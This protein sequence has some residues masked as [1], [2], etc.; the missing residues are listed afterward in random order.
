MKTFLTLLGVYTIGEGLVL[1]L[2]PRSYLSFRAG[3][4]KRLTNK[5][6]RPML[7]ER[8]N[9]ARLIGVLESILGLCLVRRWLA[10]SADLSLKATQEIEI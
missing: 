9:I 2:L 5:E 1:A 8:S 7:L 3:S 4:I 6:M 10:H